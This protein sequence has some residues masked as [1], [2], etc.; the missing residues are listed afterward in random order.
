MI[1]PETVKQL[2]QSTEQ[3]CLTL[4]FNTGPRD[5]RNAWQAR[6][7]KLLRNLDGMVLGRD[8]HAFDASVAR[9]T[10]F[11]SQYQPRG[12]SF[13]AYATRDTWQEFTS[14][15][16]VRDELHWGR[17]DVSQLLWLLEEYRP[18][19]VLIADRQHVRF[20]A[21]RMDEFEEFREFHTEIDTRDWR[22]QVIG[23]SG[24][25][26]VNVKGGRDAQAFDARCME[27]LRAF[28]RTL[29]KPLAELLDRFHIRRL[30]LAGNRS[31]LPE[32][33]QSLAPS[34]SA[35]I[36][37]QIPLESFTNPAEA[38]KRIYPAIVEWE[39]GRDNRL[40]AELLDAAS[41]SRKAAVGIEAA[42]RL[43]QEGRAAK[44]LIARGF[45]RPLS[46]C[47]DC[48]HVTGAT[49]RTCP[50]CGKPALGRTTVAAT[51]PRLVLSHNVPVEVIKGAAGEQL[52]KN[53][54]VGV[55][56]RF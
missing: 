16:P 52:S 9:I 22:R 50:L 14:R 47:A 39:T 10:N 7:K 36:V 19:G 42:A 31:L 34:I 33:S 26:K 5:P 55:F 15:V 30:V 46:L 56:L 8:R 23:S 24:R 51:L 27:R 43:I 18:Y 45:D 29:D 3:Q 48:G 17:P 41:I 6:F 21:V 53:G 40:V 44:L 28:W 32:F 37:S 11:L 1:P 20:L 49:G 35:A 2:A 38:V 54:G 4:Y 13:L 25:G 12:N